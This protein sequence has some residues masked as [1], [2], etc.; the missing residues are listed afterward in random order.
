MLKA[1]RWEFEL[2]AFCSVKLGSR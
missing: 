2:V 1:A